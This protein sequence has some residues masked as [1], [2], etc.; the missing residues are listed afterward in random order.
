M[1]P[2]ARPGLALPAQ[3]YL[4]RP[5]IPPLGKSAGPG[6][7]S[8]VNRREEPMTSTRTAAVHPR[9]A[10]LVRQIETYVRVRGHSARWFGLLV[11]GDA[12]LVPSLKR[13]RYVRPANIRAAWER[14]GGTPPALPPVLRPGAVVRFLHPRCGPLVGTVLAT[15]EFR[16]GLWSNIRHGQGFDT[17]CTRVRS[18]AVLAEIAA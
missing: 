13:G 7:A 5:S 3:H 6:E 11:A 15:G 10:A 9:H 12:N 8:P 16:S 2:T 18:S 1:A 4:R 14:V 17:E